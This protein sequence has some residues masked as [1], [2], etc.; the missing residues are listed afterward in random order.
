[1][2]QIV[3]KDSGSCIDFWTSHW[4]WQ[5]E[6]TLELALALNSKCLKTFI[7]FRLTTNIYYAHMTFTHCCPSEIHGDSLDYGNTASM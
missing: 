7:K 2:K 5:N 4:S 3:Q 6:K 1:M